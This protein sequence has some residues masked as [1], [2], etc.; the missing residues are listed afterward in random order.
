[1]KII[2]TG[3]TGFLGGW[4]VSEFLV[5]EQEIVVLRNVDTRTTHKENSQYFLKNLNS[6]CREIFVD[7]LDY[8]AILKIIKNEQPDTIFHLAAVGDVTVAFDNPKLTYEVSSNG[9]LN[10]L[11]A[12]RTVSPETLFVSHTTDKVYSGN[13]VPFAESMLFNPNHI[14]EAGKVSQEHLTRLY[15][16]SYGVK[17]LTVRCGNYFGGY[18]FNFNRIVPYVIKCAING[19]PVVLRSNGRFTRDFLYVK[20]AVAVNKMILEKSSKGEL[21]AY[22]GEAF[23]F[24]LET[25]ISVIDIVKVILELCKTKITVDVVNNVLNEIPD[26]RLDCSK[27]RQELG[28]KPRFTLDQGLIETI[29]FYKDYFSSN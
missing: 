3:G 6:R 27:A 19:E 25:Q 24:S 5:D 7:I 18:D 11:E 2:I 29:D 10:L 15:S 21:N 23:N 12:I 8:E 22:F 16:K 13:Q 14:Y 1:M 28:W 17:A 26:M 20:D 4:L 9:T